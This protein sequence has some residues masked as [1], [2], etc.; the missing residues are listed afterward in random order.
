MRRIVISA[1]LFSSLLSAKNTNTLKTTL[2]NSENISFTNTETK[3]KRYKVKK[4]DTLSS[5]SKKYHVSLSKLKKENHINKK[6]ILRIGKTLQIPS[7]NVGERT[8]F[9][10]KKYSKTH[11]SLLK[12]AKR[13]LGKRYVWAANG[14]SRFDCS[15]FTKYVLRENGITIPRTSIMQAKVGK[16]ISRNNLKAGDL[17]FFDTSKKRKRYVN[18]VGIYLGNNKFIHAS[19]AKKKVMISSLNKN[20]YEARFKWGRRVSN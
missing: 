3:G 18:H 16:K 17:I 11:K 1:L 2:L 10:N 12:E 4:G 8:I 7:K 14:P 5:I 9:D 13:H 6:S 15:G 19:S 20:F